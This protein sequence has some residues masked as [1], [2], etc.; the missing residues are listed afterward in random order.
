[1]PA[2]SGL[3]ERIC[4]V[5]GV[6]Y[7]PYRYNQKYCSRKCKDRDAKKSAGV[8]DKRLVSYKENHDRITDINSK[9]RALGLSYG[10]YKAYLFMGLNPAD[11]SRALDK[12]SYE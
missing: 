9:A 2:Q 1:M 6:S 8:R 3:S 12:V 11:F 10:M 7:M 5:C 4:F